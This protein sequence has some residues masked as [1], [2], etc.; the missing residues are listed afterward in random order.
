MAQVQHEKRKGNKRESRGPWNWPPASAEV[1]D[2]AQIREASART[3]RR[4]SALTQNRPAGMAKLRI[5]PNRALDPALR[6]MT[7]P[8]AT[9][10]KLAKSS[11]SR[12]FGRTRG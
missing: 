5:G 4:Y 6:Q 9:Q 2:L 11:E 12:S 3:L 10:N 1:N 8:I 7:I